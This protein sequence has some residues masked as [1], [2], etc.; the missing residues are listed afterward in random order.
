MKQVISM[1]YLFEWINLT[2]Q[3]IMI[4]LPLNTYL[5][6]LSFLTDKS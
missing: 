5:F 4:N 3:Q 1:D 6:C 2:A